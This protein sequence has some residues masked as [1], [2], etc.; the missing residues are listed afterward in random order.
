MIHPFNPSDSFVKPATYGIPLAGEVLFWEQRFDDTSG[1]MVCEERSRELRRGQH[2]RLGRNSIVYVTIE[3]TLRL[4]DYIAARFNLTIP[5]IYRGLL[6]GTGPLVD[7]GF[8]GRLH[9]PLHNY[10]ANDYDVVAGEP[11]VW[12]EFTKLSPNAR[13]NRPGQRAQERKGTYRPFPPRK[14]E[15]VAIKDYLKDGEA[16][17]SSIPPLVEHARESA[18]KA[19]DDAR[20]G[21]NISVLAGVAVIVGIAAMLLT[22][23]LGFEDADRERDQLRQNVAELE[24][25]I[26]R[27]S[28]SRTP[29]SVPTPTQTPRST[30]TPSPTP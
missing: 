25:T 29:R 24:Q 1:T 16:V 13:W 19:A 15:R 27:L 23:W 20:R 18:R 10:T 30:P 2:L 3:A 9:L 14:R 17:T 21:R 5:D 28:T 22:V 8:V 4:P 6:V 26:N 12:M 11:F 7:P